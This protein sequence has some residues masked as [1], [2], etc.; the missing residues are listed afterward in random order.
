MKPQAV[1]FLLGVKPSKFGATPLALANSVE[2]GFPVSALETFAGEICPQD[3]RRFTYRIVPKPTL[4]RRRKRKENLTSEES[5]RLARIAKV[6]AF[7][8]DIYQDKEKVR[9]FLSRPHVMLDDKAPLDVALATGP[10]ADVVMNI[11]GRAAYSGGV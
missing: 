3:M 10:G 2:A 9:A 6:F 4:D 8:F 11:L 1:E 7:A 5:D